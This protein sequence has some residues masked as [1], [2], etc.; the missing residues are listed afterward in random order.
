MTSLRYFVLGV[1]IIKDT[2]A[3]MPGLIESPVSCGKF[4]VAV[5]ID[6]SGVLA[7]WTKAK[8][9]GNKEYKGGTYSPSE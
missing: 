6:W 4:D 3:T 7:E 2:I 8:R 5:L 9:P 1:V